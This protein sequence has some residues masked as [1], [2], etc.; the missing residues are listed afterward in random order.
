MIER[1]LT[2]V[3]ILH[4]AEQDSLNRM[5]RTTFF[6]VSEAADYFFDAQFQAACLPSIRDVT[7]TDEPTSSVPVAASLPMY[8]PTLPSGLTLLT[9][10]PEFVPNSVDEIGSASR[11]QGKPAKPKKSAEEKLAKKL[12]RQARRVYAQTVW[13]TI[14]ARSPPGRIV[15]VHAL[16]GVDSSEPARDP[17]SPHEC[18]VLQTRD[19]EDCIHIKGPYT[20]TLAESMEGMSTGYILECTNDVKLLVSRKSPLADFW[21]L[22][23]GT[24]GSRT[25]VW[26]SEGVRDFTASGATVRALE[27]LAGVRFPDAH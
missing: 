17:A 4:S 26:G 7:V 27:V 11:K 25:L 13:Q 6:N 23:L 18:L 21:T 10:A 20:V 22:T 3:L 8:L 9:G 12:E 24:S 19:S 2:P 15:D 5:E 16:T 1:R 14:P